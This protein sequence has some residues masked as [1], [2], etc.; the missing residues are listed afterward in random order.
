MEKYLTQK[1]LRQA[2]DGVPTM[3][4]LTSALCTVPYRQRSGRRAWPLAEVI[5]ALKR[6]YETKVIENEVR[7][8]VRQPREGE[9]Q[10]FLTYATV[11]R[12]RLNR[13]NELMER[14]ATT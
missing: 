3:R 13:L 10:I 6:Y 4:D 9:T 8:L 1:E 12:E 14:R 7:H 5:P 2:L 11:Y